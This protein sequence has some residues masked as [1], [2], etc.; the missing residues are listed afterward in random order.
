MSMRALSKFFIQNLDGYFLRENFLVSS[1]VTI[2]VIR[3]FLK[4]TH[5]P[6]LSGAGLHIAHLLWGGFFM[7]VSLLLLLSFLGRGIM[8]V[9]SI[10]GGI[11][12]GAFIDELGKFVTSDNNY[13]FQPTI[14]IV[15]IIFILIYI[16]SK[17]LSNPSSVSQ[18]E[19]LVNTL[20]MVAEA[21]MSDL[22]DEEKK[23]ALLYLE[24]SDPKDPL[25]KSLQAFFNQVQSIPAPQPSFPNRLKHFL[26]AL[27]SR[28][29]QNKLLILGLFIIV[30]IEALYTIVSTLLHFSHQSGLSVAEIGEISSTAIAVVVA[31]L[32]SLMMPHSRDKGLRVFKIAILILLLVTQFFTFYEEQFR[33]LIGLAINIVLLTIVDY[34]LDQ[35]E[36]VKPS[37]GMI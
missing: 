27:Y 16:I 12:F 9:S 36:N 29:L 37:E 31:L 23:R 19:Y 2:F 7:L 18:K 5:Y 15:Y 1:I 24:K 13:F 34:A 21:V 10:L 35:E 30:M 17:A 14:A 25:V 3:F 26:A 22:D 28:L 11:G 6:E 32:G 33:A 20:E 4:V 8:S